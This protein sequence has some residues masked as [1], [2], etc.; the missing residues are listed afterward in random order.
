[1]IAAGELG[2]VRLVQVEYAQDWLIDA[3]EAT[4]RS[5]RRGARI[6]SWLGRAGSVGDIGTHAFHLAEFVRDCGRL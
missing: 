5:R 4:V 1:M 2:D 6:R 3:L